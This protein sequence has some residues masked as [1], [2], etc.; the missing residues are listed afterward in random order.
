MLCIEIDFTKHHVAIEHDSNGRI[1]HQT[2]KTRIKYYNIQLK[3]NNAEEIQSMG[4][5]QHACL[6]KYTGTIQETS[7]TIQGIYVRVQQGKRNRYMKYIVFSMLT[8]RGL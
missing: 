2:Q 7:I 1:S 5:D 8:L 6:R 4:H 3:C